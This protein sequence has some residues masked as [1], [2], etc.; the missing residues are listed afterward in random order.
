MGVGVG[1]SAGDPVVMSVMEVYFRQLVSNKTIMPHDS[2][3]CVEN[4]KFELLLRPK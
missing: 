1:G 3:P 2:H 4:S